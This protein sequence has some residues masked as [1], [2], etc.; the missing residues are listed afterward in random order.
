M[1]TITILTAAKGSLTDKIKMTLT[2]IM[3]D[4]IYILPMIF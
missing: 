3:L 1:I 4:C 2:A